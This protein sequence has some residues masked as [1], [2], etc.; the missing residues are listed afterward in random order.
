MTRVSKCQIS[1]SWCQDLSYF[2]NESQTIV[3]D[4]L[5]LNEWK[6]SCV[7]TVTHYVPHHETSQFNEIKWGLSDL[8]LEGL[9]V[10][11]NCL[12]F[13][14]NVSGYNELHEDVR[15]H[16]SLFIGCINVSSYVYVYLPCFT[17]YCR[18]DCL[19]SMFFLFPM[20]VLLVNTSTLW[21]WWLCLCVYGLVHGFVHVWLSV[22]CLCVWDG[23]VFITLSLSH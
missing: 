14:C 13:P 10:T 12:C 2:I 22:C 11:N 9:G 21:W 6:P 5:T 7:L 1:H 23:S 20:M 18:F 4:L 17:D 16:S 19:C 15:R 8:V 3:F